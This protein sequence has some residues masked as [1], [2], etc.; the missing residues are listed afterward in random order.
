MIPEVDDARIR[1]F[2]N[3]ICLQLTAS[4]WE[5]V[6][7]R[8]A[9][10]TLGEVGDVF[11]LPQAA[12]R[13]SSALDDWKI[14]LELCIAELV[15]EDR[16]NITAQETH[17]VALFVQERLSVLTCGGLFAGSEPADVLTDLPTP[18]VQ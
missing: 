18:V 1:Q 4:V 8:V 3:L 6:V 17:A 15:C 5:R 7:M 14:V 9:V 13:R 11:A 10:E 12:E 16:G 2:A